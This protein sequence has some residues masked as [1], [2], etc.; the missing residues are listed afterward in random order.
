MQI[1]VTFRHMDPIATIKEYAEQKVSRVKKYLDN[2]LEANVILSVEKHR[3][4]AD[5]TVN[6]N[7]FTIVGEEESGDLQSA[8][9]L[10]MQKIERQI[11]K[12]KGKRASRKNSSSVTTDRL[13]EN[14]IG[15]GEESIDPQIVKTS[16]SILK[17]M[18][19][20][21]AISEMKVLKQDFLIYS[22]IE[23]NLIN[24][25]YRRNDGNFELIEA[26]PE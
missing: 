15:G 1:S 9:D 7:G 20:E 4:L 10:V 25:L 26:V 17:P 21:E 11:R 6:A 3:H 24:V 8:I 12:R 16:H 22:D 23:S 5:V 2:P 13:R 19:I 18:S 14:I